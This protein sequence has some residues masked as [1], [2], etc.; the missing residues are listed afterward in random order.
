MNELDSLV[1]ERRRAKLALMQVAL[2]Q[3]GYDTTLFE[4]SPERAAPTVVVSLDADEEKR[5]REMNV[6]IM[7]LG[8][9]DADATEF[10]QFFLQYP[11]VVGEDVRSAVREAATIVNNHLAVG[12]FGLDATGAVF[13]RYVL[14]TPLNAM[15]DNHLLVEL[16]TFLDYTQ[17]QFGDY[18]EGVADDEISVLVLD[19]VIRTA[20]AAEAP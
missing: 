12:H 5:P 13:F 17:Q 3:A 11:F 1:G 16:M 14:A 8:S 7:P 2:Q 18:L 19:D 9:E 6:T 4:A 10:V 20:E 15:L